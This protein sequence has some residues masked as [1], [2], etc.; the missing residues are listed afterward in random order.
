MTLRNPSLIHIR[1][2][3]STALCSGAASIKLIKE[4]ASIPAYPYPASRTY[5]QS[6]FGL[7]GGTHIQFGNTIS[8]RTEIKN[9]RKWL[10]NIHSK[11][12]WSASLK[13]WLKIKV[14]SRA[15]RT[16]DKV[17]GLDEY[18]L[19]E[20][21]ARIKE[22]GM[23]GWKL[24]WRI[25]QTESVKLRFAEERARLGVSE[26]QQSL[27]EEFLGILGTPVTREQQREDV[28]AF[29]NELDR[30]DNELSQNGESDEMGGTE[31]Q[32]LIKENEGRIVK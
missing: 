29:D 15:L 20:K 24:R 30:K 9:R 23:G 25:M 11:R 16:I 1:P 13:R 4:H 5:K 12:L 26:T 8:E 6:N 27:P 10:P 31:K 3:S 7:Y 19:G 21:P 28:E 32:L 17:G 14:S 18:L 2:F 22:L